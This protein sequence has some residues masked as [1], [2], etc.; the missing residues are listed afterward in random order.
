MVA[1]GEAVLEIFIAN[2]RLA[3]SIEPTVADLGDPAPSLLRGVTP[4]ALFLLPAIDDIWDVAVRFD[5]A[6][7]GLA[8]MAGIS[9]QVLAAPD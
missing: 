7:R 6:C 8:S 1:H 3:K 2:E 5:K 9:T 4:L